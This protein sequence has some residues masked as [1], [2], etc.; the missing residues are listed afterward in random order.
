MASTYSTSLKLELIGNGDQS[1]VWGTTTNKNLGTLLEQAITGVQSIVMTNANYTLTNFNGT[2]DEA[3]NAV[4]VVTGTNGATRKII[5]P[6]VKKTYIVYNNTTGGFNITIGGATGNAVT[7]PNGVTTLVYCDGTNFFNG[8]TGLTGNFIVTGDATISG[9]LGVGITSPSQELQVY[10]NINGTTTLEVNNPNAGT[11]ASARLV[12]SPEN[13]SVN[14]IANSSTNTGAA[15]TGGANGAGLYTTSTLTNGLSVGTTAGPLKFFAGSTSVERMRINSTGNVG[16]GTTATTYKL[17]IADT[18][19]DVQLWVRNTGTDASDDAIILIQT[20][21]TGTTATISGLYFGD[22]DSNSIGQLRYNHSND[23]M[24]FYTDS[25]I[26]FTISST[27]G[28]SIVRT[29]VTSPAAADGNVFSGTYT[30]T[31]TNVT[32]VAASTTGVC[33][34]MRVGNVVTVSG[35]LSIN[36]TTASANTV[37]RMTLPIASSFTGTSRALGGTAASITSGTYGQSLAILG[38]T[39]A[40]GQAEFRGDPTVATDQDYAFS[41]TYRII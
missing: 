27:G 2:S 15:I 1:G 38:F 41:F 39:S 22:G 25:T 34:Y 9:N 14:L 20:S 21:G 3:R 29:G 7:I 4:L 40:T 30:P 11:S 32:N 6:L 37:L 28:I 8:F 36:P 23:S 5:T 35:Q 24:V 17:S 16:I 18:G 12:L 19:S 31:L 26:A 13:G 33:Q 10:K